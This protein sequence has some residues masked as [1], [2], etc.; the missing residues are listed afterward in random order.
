LGLIL[1][2]GGVGASALGKLKLN[3]R[4]MKIWI[5]AMVPVV[6]VSLLTW[7]RCNQL[8]SPVTGAQIEAERHPQSARAN[9]SAALALISA[10]YGNGSDA[11][12][13]KLIQYYLTQAGIADPAYKLNYLGLMVWACASGRTIDRVWV[14]ELAKRLSETPLS[15]QDRDMP[16]QI[17]NN[18]MALPKCLDR[19]DALRLFEA[20]ALNLKASALVQARFLDAASDYQL[21][22]SVDPSSAREYLMRAVKAAPNDG[23]LQNKL[24]GFDQMGHLPSEEGVGRRR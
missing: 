13:G 16:S 19:R 9:Y 6:V 21:L 24:A 10:G 20:G 7:L 3:H 5:V 23:N 4:M 11:V 18:L 8:G 15:P 2:I 17:L 1:G 14:D 12:G 22:V